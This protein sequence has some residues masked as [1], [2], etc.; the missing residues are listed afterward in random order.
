MNPTRALPLSAVPL[1]GLIACLVAA[2]APLQAQT[3]YRIVGPDGRV[4]FSDKPAQD[5][6]AKPAASGAAPNA[7]ANPPTAATADANATLPYALRQVMAQYPV[8]LYTGADCAPCDTGRALL[9]GRGVPFAEK[10]ISSNEDIEALKRLSGDTSLPVLTLGGQKI[11]GLSETQWAQYLDTAGYPKKSALP[12]SYRFAAASPLVT[13]PKPAPETPP[14]KPEVKTDSSSEGQAP[15]APPS[16][17]NPNNPA[18]IS[19]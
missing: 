3:V 9:K 17:R 15:K 5:A 2:A 12:A 13:L 8:T 4:T 6:A 19:F 16:T 1:V 10:T 7:P 14:A 18:G 11:K